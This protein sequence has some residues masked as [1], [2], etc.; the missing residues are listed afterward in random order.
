MDRRGALAGLAGLAMTPLL[1]SAHAEARE[2]AFG[3]IRRLDPELDR[4]V[5]PDAAVRRL[6]SGFRWAEGPVW[7]PA[8]SCL[9]FGDP[10]RNTVH[11]WSAKAGLEVFLSPSGL[12]S[13]V[14]A[15]IREPGLN[16]LALDTGGR[17]IAADSGTRAIVRIDIASRNRETLADRFEGKRF[18]SPNDLC[19]SK[20]GAIYF[21]DP[22]YGLAE[23]DDS[24]LRELPWCGLYRLSPDGV[25]HLL[26][27]RHRRPNGVALSPDERTLYLALSDEKQPEVLAYTLSAEGIAGEPRRFLDMRAD[28][29]AG[30]P[31][32]PDGIKVAATGHV[33]A[34]GPGGVHVCTAQGRRLG[35]IET[36]KAVANCAIGQGGKSL[37]L[38]SSDSLAM[39][40]LVNDQP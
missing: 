22:T 38:T 28:L 18:N 31:G 8:E 17:L 3:A 6:A 5:A 1:R 21:T 4:I 30:R 39:V 13:P 37:F 14:P 26:D 2:P 29:A 35:V 10:G 40:P 34:T 11:R 25:L 23:G 15:G 24:P 16:G 27:R 36:G 19:V 12:Q 7:V 32:L 33:F 9:L 20:S